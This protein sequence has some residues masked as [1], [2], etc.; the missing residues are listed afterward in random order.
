MLQ[1]V[2]SLIYYMLYPN[3]LFSRLPL[4]NLIIIIIIYY[5][6][7]LLLSGAHLLCYPGAFNMTTGPLHWELLQRAR[8]IFT[9][10]YFMK[11]CL[12]VVSQGWLDLFCFIS[13]LR[14]IR[15]FLLL[16]GSFILSIIIG[17]FDR[18]TYAVLSSYMWR[19]AHLPEIQELATLLG[20]TLHSL[21][22]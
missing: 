2:N 15:Y 20:D 19:H 1:E 8:Y 12:G 6:L 16:S 4:K 10:S 22:L 7:V 17:A 21:G 11:T 13:G 5:M 9:V 14:I 18:T 3:G